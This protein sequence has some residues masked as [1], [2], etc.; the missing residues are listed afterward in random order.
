MLR[1]S[2]NKISFIDVVNPSHLVLPAPSAHH[3]ICVVSK[4]A[5]LFLT[6]HPVARWPTFVSGIFH[7][8]PEVGRKPLRCSEHISSP[9]YVAPKHGNQMLFSL[10]YSFW[11]SVHVSWFLFGSWGY[12]PFICQIAFS[13]VYA[14]HLE[15]LGIEC[16]KVLW[17][18]RGKDQTANR[19]INNLR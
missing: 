16:P 8:F 3:I 4:T 2:M 9:C 12:F 6:W 17:T 7:Q 13:L 18:G 10:Y 19:T 1:H 15:Q 14:V 5:S 11:R